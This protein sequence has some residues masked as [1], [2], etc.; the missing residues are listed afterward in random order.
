MDIWAALRS[1]ARDLVLAETCAGCGR[2]GGGRTVCERCRRELAPAPWPVEPMIPLTHFPPTYAASRYDGVV[3]ALVVGHKEEGRL[4]LARPLGRLLAAAVA[5]SCARQAEPGTDAIVMVP[6]PSRRAATRRRGHDPVRAMARAAARSLPHVD[7]R[8]RPVLRHRRTV[9][10]QSG[11][12]VFERHANL[13]DALVVSGPARWPRTASIVVVDDIC[14]SG[15]TLTAAA[16]ALTA[17]GVPRARISAAVVAAPTLR[18]GAGDTS[19]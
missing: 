2:P 9:A 3:R 16:Q 18:T 1:A 19:G 8:V 4:A 13:S 6:V 5:A 15:A 10:D 11:L 7:S 14:S 12:D 17:A